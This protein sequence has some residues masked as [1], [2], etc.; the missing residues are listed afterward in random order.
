LAGALLL[1]DAP[2]RMERIRT[3]RVMFK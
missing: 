2:C 3:A 1:A